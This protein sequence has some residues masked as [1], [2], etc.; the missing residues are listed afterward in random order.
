V[1]L[2]RNALAPI[3]V[4]IEPNKT[5]TKSGDGLYDALVIIVSVEVVVELSE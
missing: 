4:T 3:E 1:V 2:F 5:S